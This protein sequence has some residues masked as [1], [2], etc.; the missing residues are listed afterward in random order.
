ME[1]L[2]D[3]KRWLRKG[4]Y[5]VIHRMLPGS[6]IHTIS[7][8][9]SGKRN[10][11]SKKALPIIAAAKKIAASRQKLLEPQGPAPLP[12]K[13]LEAPPNQLHIFADAQTVPSFIEKVPE[14]Q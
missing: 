4:D 14:E 1:K 11:T 12:E 6:S 2:L 8:V 13:R 5:E 7:S 9:M 10:A 3:I